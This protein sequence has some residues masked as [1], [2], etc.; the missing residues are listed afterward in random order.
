M[1]GSFFRALWSFGSNQSTWLEGADAVMQ[2][3]RSPGL[4]SGRDF[5]P[6]GTAES[7]PRVSAVPPG[8][9]ISHRPTQDSVL[10]TSSSA[11][12]R[13]PLSGLDNP[14]SHTPSKAQFSLSPLRPDFKSDPDTKHE[15][16]DPEEE[17]RI[18]A[19]LVLLLNQL[20]TVH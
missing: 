1:L 8:L 6:V 7:I 12:F 3:G 11:K 18:F 9:F 20:L 10:R 13:P 2:S 14:S 19:D 15:R 17:S 5:S 4:R 16:R